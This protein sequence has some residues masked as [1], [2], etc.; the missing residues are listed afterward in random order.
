MLITFWSLYRNTKSCLNRMR[1]SEHSLLQVSQKLKKPYCIQC[2]QHLIIMGSVCFWCEAIRIRSINRLNA[3]GWGL[4]Y[5][6]VLSCHVL[7]WGLLQ[8]SFFY[9]GKFGFSLSKFW[10]FGFKNI[11]W[12][13]VGFFAIVTYATL[14]RSRFYSELDIANPIWSC[15]Q[16]DRYLMQ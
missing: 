4:C 7:P 10:V 8:R 15:E 12:F 5:D 16:R 6:N 2:S 13:Q 9:P 11:G 1:K 3:N 14:L